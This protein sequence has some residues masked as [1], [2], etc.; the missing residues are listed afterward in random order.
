M[1]QPDLKTRL[2]ELEA[3]INKAEARLRLKGLLSADHQATAAELRDRY[4]ALTARL[5][6]EKADAE[7]HGHHVGDLELSVRQWLD[8]LEIEMD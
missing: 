4:K 8:S 2:S 7:A 5:R 3:H 6:E 1:P